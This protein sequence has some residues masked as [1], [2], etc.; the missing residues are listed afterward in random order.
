MTIHFKNVKW[1]NFLST[2]NYFSE[3]RLDE[4][5]TT[6]I[7][8]ANGN[9]KSTFLDAISFALYG[10]AYRDINKPQLCNSINKK[11]MV[12]EIEFSIGSIEYKV[13][14]G[15]KPAI[16]ELWKDGI[17]VPP[18]AA[19]GDLQAHLENDILRMSHKTFCQIIVL[20]SANFVPFMQLTPASRR[21][22]LENLLDLQVFSIMNVILKEKI[23]ENYE[24]VKSQRQSHLI[25]EERIQAKIDLIKKLSSGTDERRA[26]LEDLI[27]K[28]EV[29]I[30]ETN[31]QIIINRR[32]ADDLLECNRDISKLSENRQKISEML[33]KGKFQIQKYTS[34]IQFY[35]SN[36]SCPVCRQDIN[37]SFKED[38][39]SDTRSKSEKIDSTLIELDSKLESI[40][41]EIS[42]RESI[43]MELNLVQQ[44]ISE[45]NV[46][47][48]SGNEYISRIQKELDKLNQASIQDIHPETEALKILTEER[49][50]IEKTLEELLNKKAVL[51]T[52]SPL[53][54]DGGIK[55]KIIKQYIPIINRLINYY[56]N[57][58]GL[59]V[60]FELDENFKE[61]I[62]SRFRDDFS[63]E[64]FSEGEK[65]RLDLAILLT[66]RSVAKM[67]NS[68][69]SNLL[70]LD[71]I[72]D[73][74][75][76]T[77]GMENLCDMIEKIFV[78]ENLIIIS[79]R[80]SMIESF[81]NIIRFE[82]V[83]DFSRRVVDETS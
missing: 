79:H 66:W 36:D 34:D 3:I 50:E 13:V 74:S 24:M 20:G 2:G 67:R 81:S 69:S 73:G 70:V 25:I 57:I 51:E 64:S 63:Y 72:L 45:L 30:S 11:N 80:E 61:T 71:E 27:K 17:S 21:E 19:S 33:T 23:S 54:K 31:G 49:D 8:G 10:K 68:V 15:I 46:K 53:L 7:V 39:V 37:A 42:Y 48:T 22:V 82:K 6:L 75:L 44:K 65:K 77:E 32:M 26:E 12:V 52:A 38:I 62:K 59:P 60:G 41:A 29:M 9:G 76:D 83:K 58:F 56:L 5:P 78:D 28:Y 4:H 55:S 16:L 43:S 47:V 18:P 35:E 40:L 1:K 14:R